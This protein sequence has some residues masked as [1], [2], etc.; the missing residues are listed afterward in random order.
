MPTAKPRQTTA[1][2]TYVGPGNRTA[3]CGR[4]QCGYRTTAKDYTG[5]RQQMRQHQL[6]HRW[7][8]P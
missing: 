7:S 8:P 1:I 6:N 4:P 2:A 5:A 3:V